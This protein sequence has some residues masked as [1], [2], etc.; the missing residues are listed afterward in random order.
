MTTSALLLAIVLVMVGFREVT[1]QMRGLDRI[2]A[3][4]SRL[5][6][7]RPKRYV[8]LAWG[9]SLVVLGA[10]ML[11][12]PLARAGWILAGISR[13]AVIPTPCSTEAFN[14]YL[15][16]RIVRAAFFS[17]FGIACIAFALGMI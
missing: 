9:W 3:Q 2:S 12:P 8:N 16:L 7:E 10:G 4:G 5:P 17:A 15:P 6:G 11:W 1:I 14:R 13:L